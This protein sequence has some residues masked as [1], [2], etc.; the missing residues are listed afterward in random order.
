[1]VQTLASANI[2]AHVQGEISGQVAIGNHIVQI[3]SVH[4]G[5]VNII[6]PEQGARPRPRPVPVFL[7]PR[8]FPGLLDR[9]TDIHAAN[10]ALESASPVEFY[11]QEGIGKTAL[12]RHLAHRPPNVP[13]PDGILYLRTRHQPLADL[14]QFLYDTFYESDVPFKPT[15][16]QLRHGLQ[17][18]R[19]LILLDD[20]DLSRDEVEALVYAAPRSTFLLASP[21]RHL[22]GEGR[23][24]ALRGLPPEDAL[25]LLER[26]LGR[27]LTVEERPAAQALCTALDG[28]PLHI[29]Q[30]ASMTR[31]EGHPLVEIAQRVRSVS[32]D[33]ALTAQVLA[34]L[35]EP[36]RRVL[37][38]LAV[39]NGASLKADHL[40]ELTGLPDVTPV[41]ETLL[42]RGLIQAHSPRYTLTGTLEQD[43]RQRALNLTPWAERALAYFTT[44]AERHRTATDRLLEEADAILQLLAWGVSAGRWAEV[45]RLGRA[46]E[47]ALA[48]GKRWG[49]WQRV[50]NLLRRAAQALGDRAA[51]AWALHQLGTRALCLEDTATARTFLIRA[52]HTREALGD[53]IGAEVTRH[54]LNLLLGPPPSR[55]RPRQRPPE[56]AGGVLA[57]LDIPLLVVLAVS[58]LALAVLGN[59]LIRSLRESY[60]PIS[61]VTAISP[62]TAT[63]TSSLTLT[64]MATATATETPTPTNTPTFTPT[65]TNTP[66]PTFTR[67]PCGVPPAHWVPYTVQPRDGLYMLARAR[68]DGADTEVA[69]LVNLIVFYNCLEGTGLQVGQ[70]LYLPPLPTPPPD[71]KGPDA[72]TLLQP[73]NEGEIPCSTEEP[74]SVTLRWQPVDDP[75]GVA[76]YEMELV[77]HPSYPPVAVTTTLQIEGGQSQTT[78]RAVCGDK[79][80]W[81]GRAVDNVGNNGEWSNWSV[82]YLL[83]KEPTP[84]DLVITTLQ[85]SGPATFVPDGGVEVPIRVIVRNQ[86]GTAADTFKVATLYSIEDA[87]NVIPFTVP[88]QDDRWYPFTDGPLAAGSEEAFDGVVTFFGMQGRVIS[89]WAEA[90][91][92]AGDEVVFD[93]CRVEESDEDNNQSTSIRISLPQRI[94]STLYCVA[95]AYVD[96][97]SP[98]G[99]YG[100]ARLLSIGTVIPE[101]AELSQRSFI[102]FD[103]ASIPAGAAIETAESSD[104]SFIR[105]DLSSIPAGAAIEDATLLLYL[106]GWDRRY[107]D[108]TSIS[109]TQVLAEWTEADINWN[110]QPDTYWPEALDS[111]LVTDVLGDYSWN[112]TS[113]V[114]SWVNEPGDNYGIMLFGE[115]TGPLALRVFNSREYPKL[116]LPRL[117]IRYI[118]VP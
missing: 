96:S 54:N 16:A 91:S 113:L 10:D 49:A 74:V 29:L 97:S 80:D 5:V 43:L 4:G 26:E 103:L 19:A 7:R 24:L 51:E 67:R 39:L 15:D 87:T 81:R 47:G 117:R 60:Q 65:P 71:V 14:L 42:Q 23:A 27:P 32:P 93:Y 75:S 107:A 110:N 62:P 41:L 53:R 106:T 37:A 105:F 108:E 48:L 85:T 101:F 33:K 28:H 111:T 3:G 13:F 95:D 44:W 72:P 77:R 84:P 76:R 22:W 94:S 92:C 100:S 66:T 118:T 38:A 70:R 20:V 45:L 90:D 34:S 82:F 18:K 12:L 112:V 109:V 69:N 8:P 52:L 25:T 114:Q 89:L 78:I 46:I 73:K 98:S 9:A 36:G 61:T 40:S 55:W 35:P 88:G 86:G 30:A 83:P 6:T 31:E 102:R 21:Q 59:S 115:E 11:G 2:Q 1:M 64:P 99:N 50:L 17:D 57:A 63:P 79:Y 104:R 56:S 116:P 58:L 68:L